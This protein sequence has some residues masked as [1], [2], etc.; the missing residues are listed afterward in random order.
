MLDLERDLQIVEAI[1]ADLK[2]HLLGDSLYWTL[3]ASGPS[4]YPF[5]KGTLGGLL[6]RLHRLEAL[7]HLLS[8]EQRR[9]LTEAAAQAREQMN[10]WAVQ[11]WQK[12]HRE[13]NTRLDAWAA[14]LD[15]CEDDP[16]RYGPEYPVQAEGRTI[17]ALL[18]DFAGEPALQSRLDQLDRRLASLVEESNFVWD[19]VQAPAFPRSRF[20]WLYVRPAQKR[21]KE[22]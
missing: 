16:A 18:M 7:A 15:E 3:R 11:A 1:T 13:I 5:P 19:A 14:Y 9:R 17:V 8:S 20:G 22:A 10:T 4:S 6:L 21:K 2:A 12:A